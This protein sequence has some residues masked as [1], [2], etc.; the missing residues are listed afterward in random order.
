MEVRPSYGL[1]FILSCPGQ[2]NPSPS[3]LPLLMPRVIRG[4]IH[5]LS[6]GKSSDPLEGE[7][8]FRNQEQPAHTSAHKVGSEGGI[9]GPELSLVGDRLAPAKLLESLVNPSAE[10]THGYGLS[11][12]SLLKGTSL[13]G[14]IAEKKDGIVTVIAPDGKKTA[15]RE[16][17]GEGDFTARFRHAS[18]GAHL[19]AE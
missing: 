15:M 6:L 4:S 17:S 1:T 10:I 14:R 8:V 13:V 16:G 12:I 7:K 11:N 2:T 9:Q 5:A 19:V 3:K 18:L